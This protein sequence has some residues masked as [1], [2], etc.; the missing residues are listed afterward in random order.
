MR[1]DKMDDTLRGIKAGVQINYNKKSIQ[2]IATNLSLIFL[3]YPK[4][5][6]ADFCATKNL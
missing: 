1:I 3:I 4:A 5:K 6:I 2:L